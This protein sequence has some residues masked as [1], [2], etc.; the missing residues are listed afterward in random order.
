MQMID[1][2]DFAGIMLDSYDDTA[3]VAREFFVARDW[4]LTVLAKAHVFRS[5]V[6]GRV[7]ED[8]RFDLNPLY[9]SMG[10]VLVTDSVLG[11]E[12][13]IRSH[14]SLKIERDF[15]DE[16]TLDLQ[17]G[18]VVSGVKLLVYKFG[19]AGLSL[20][21][22]ESYTKSGSTRLHPDGPPIQIGHWPSPS[23]SPEG[24]TGEFNQGGGTNW[25]QIGDISDD[26]GTDV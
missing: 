21:W 25:D 5:A 1:V 6:Q 2:D 9:M 16:P 11:S 17:V 22:C 10:R 20:S 8:E 15:E 24:D 7:M 14:S 3:T 4:P 12:L 23:P 18:R 19:P 13:L 26:T